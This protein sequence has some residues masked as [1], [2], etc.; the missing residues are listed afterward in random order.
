[1]LVELFQAR[2]ILPQMKIW[3]AHKKGGAAPE[4]RVYFAQGQRMCVYTI[5]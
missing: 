3:F 1:M 4:R 5:L 2:V